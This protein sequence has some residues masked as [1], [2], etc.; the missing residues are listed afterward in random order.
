MQAVRHE[1][2]GQRWHFQHGPIDLLIQAD[3]APDAVAAAH[4]VAWAR[5]Q[6]VLAEL[7]SELPGLR[8]AVNPAGT[9]P[10]QGSV[11]RRMWL[12]SL[13]HAANFITPMAAVAGAV[14]EEIV[15]AYDRPGIARAWVNNGGDAAFHLMPGSELSVGLFADLGRLPQG[16]DEPALDGG[17]RI[18]ASLPIRGVATSGWRGRSFSMGVADSVTILAASASA[19]DAAATIVANAV[20]VD[21]PGIV[22]RPANTL[23]DDTD[24]GD[25]LVTVDVPVLAPDS[26]DQ[27]LAAGAL[28]ARR[29]RGRGLIEAAVLICQ[30]GLRTVGLAEDDIPSERGN[31]SML[32]DFRQI[33]RLPVVA[34]SY[35]R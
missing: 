1:M 27:A 16:H 26:R 9:C 11:A 14:A 3:G 21:L 28:V 19:A 15:V 31:G 25:R 7:V 35:C 20:D 22:R 8:L 4:E 29:L 2:D 32:A 17:F 30:G 6:G 34:P 12:A 13:P 24:L 10:L 5:F 18:D 23:K 33:P